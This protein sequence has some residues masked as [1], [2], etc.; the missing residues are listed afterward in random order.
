[1]NESSQ[2]TDTH[3]LVGR[4]RANLSLS[5]GMGIVLLLALVKLL[6]HLW[7]NR[8]YGYFRDELYFL[9]CGE[10]L[11]WGYVDQ[12]PMV[13][14]V[15][16]LSRAL[17]GDSLSPIRFFPAVAGALKVLLAGLMARELGGGRFAAGLGGLVEAERKTGNLHALRHESAGGRGDVRPTD[18]LAGLLRSHGA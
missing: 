10:H 5:A 16:W 14:G 9:A 4:L 15:A 17:F 18:A 8:G 12:A 13:A 1:M 11:D 3:S 6:L 2:I 7:A